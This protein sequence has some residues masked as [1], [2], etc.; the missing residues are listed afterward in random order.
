VQEDDPH[1]ITDLSAVEPIDFKYVN[2]DFL[3]SQEHTYE[4]TG[5]ESHDQLRREIWN[6]RNGDLQKILE[7]FPKDDQLAEQCAGW[8][9]AVAGKHFFPDANHRTAMGLLRR[10]LAENHIETGSWEAGFTNYAV[11]CSH[12]IRRE[13]DPVA[14]DTLYRRDWMFNIWKDYFEVVLPVVEK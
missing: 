1:R 8:V 5:R 14:L 7:R 13:I 2:T 6:V 10:L 3:E 12:E 9:H 11:R 4:R